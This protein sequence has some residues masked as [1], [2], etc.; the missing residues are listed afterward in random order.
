M[1]IQ[2][3]HVLQSSVSAIKNFQDSILHKSELSFELKEVKIGINK[4]SKIFYTSIDFSPLVNFI[5]KGD[6]EF[7]FLLHCA[8][9]D[10]EQKETP[11][12]I[13]PLKEK[14]AYNLHHNPCC[15][16]QEKA[17]LAINYNFLNTKD[18][19]LKTS[20]T[21]NSI[22]TE[23]AY[24]KPI[25]N[26]SMEDMQNGKNLTKNPYSLRRSKRIAKRKLTVEESSSSFIEKPL[27]KKQKASFYHLNY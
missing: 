6:I 8:E 15:S 23:H 7:E 10:E 24:A 25:K 27:P 9:Q 14:V 3:K 4:I 5:N 13:A 18:V 20:N 16:S 2:E 11:K 1:L 17:T 12:P 22:I 19:I 21:N 26:A